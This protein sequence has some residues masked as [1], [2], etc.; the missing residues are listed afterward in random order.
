MQA[1]GTNPGRSSACMSTA[2]PVAHEK[3]HN[4]GRTLAERWQNAAGQKAQV[5]PPHWRKSGGADGPG[6]GPTG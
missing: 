3:L 2:V 5:L 6:F 4:A 1:A